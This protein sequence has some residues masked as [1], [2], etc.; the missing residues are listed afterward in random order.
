M[1]NINNCTQIAEGKGCCACPQ[2]CNPQATGC[3]SGIGGD[4][5]KFGTAS[6]KVGGMN[7]ALASKQGA[8]ILAATHAI[9]GAA[10]VASV[11][12]LA[13]WTGRTT[14]VDQTPFLVVDGEEG[15]YATLR[16][17]TPRLITPGQQIM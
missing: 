15:E 11:A 8:G 5:C 7:T 10:A 12:A 16:D 14:N 6:T 3:C 1:G 9:P 4:C 17:E 13:A 2:C